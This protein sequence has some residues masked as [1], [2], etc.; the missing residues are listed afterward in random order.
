MALSFTSR[1]RRGLP[2]EFIVAAVAVLIWAG[3]QLRGRPWLLAPPSEPM[4]MANEPLRA[5]SGRSDV[6]VVL[7]SVVEAN[8]LDAFAW[9]RTWLN[10]IEQEIGQAHTVRAGE[11]TRS[12][13]DAASWVVV[14]AGAAAQLDP[15]Q[16]QFLHNWVEDGG[17][18]LLEQPEGPWQAFTGQA[19][20]GARR[21]DTRRIT[22]FDGT[23]SRADV[24]DDLLEFPF[25][26]N[27][28]LYNP[29]N[30]ARGRDYQVLLEVDGQPGIVTRQL[31]RGHVYLLLFDFSELVGQ[32]QQGLP[33]DDLHLPAAPDVLPPGLT[34]THRAVRD[35]ALY[36]NSI[37]FADLLER[38]VLALLDQQRPIAR[39][40]MYPGHYRGALIVTH[41]EDRF[42]PRAHFQTEWE[43]SAGLRSTVFAT[44]G[45]MS[46]EQLARMARQGTDVQLQWHPAASSRAPHRTWGIRD[47]RPIHRAMTFAEQRERLNQDLL[48]YGPVRVTRIPNGVWTTRW[49]DGFRQLDAHGVELDMTWGPSPPSL[50]DST[51]LVGYLFG[52]GY[53]FRPIDTNG[54]RFLVQELPTAL[55]DLAAGYDLARVRRLLVEASDRYHTTVVGDWRPDTMAQRPSH[56]ALEGWRTAFRIAEQQDL[57]ITTAGD[58]LSFLRQ[59][60]TSRI[61]STFSPDERRLGIE[62]VL[63]PPTT[64]VDDPEQSTPALA[65]PTRYQGRPVDRLM[66]DGHPVELTEL[67][68]SADRLL[69]YLALSPG[70]HR[71]QVFYGSPFE[72]ETGGA[73]SDGRD[74]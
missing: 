20:S 17:L 54:E 3:S 21:R 23:L 10:A 14:P 9:D 51:P 40:W 2:I 8:S 19:F 26:T 30:L 64:P 48:P 74:R 49:L 69:N 58:Y 38:Q 73:G 70:E 43:A 28:L 39:L 4:A 33:S 56:D 63:Q 32:T 13:I 41:S 46:P 53:P 57:W 7:P 65:F 35:S 34:T 5:Q 16:T 60:Q 59:R 71:I 52:T 62:V 72:A 22:S 47:F 29:P 15:T 55:L 68:V 1:T 37:P 66:V 45:T 24:R 31:G 25:R 36:E 6:L 42:G 18:L 12:E 67:H 44:T 61:H 27:L 11:L 50:T